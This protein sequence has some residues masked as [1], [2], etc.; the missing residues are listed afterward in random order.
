MG[1]TRLREWIGMSSRIVFFGGAGTSTESGIP[2]F[3]SEAGLFTTKQ[4]S[5]HSPEEMLSRSFFEQ[6][7]KEFYRFYYRKMIHADAE[8]NSGHQALAELEHRGKLR[9]IITQ[10]IDGLHQKAGSKS[11][12]ELHGSVHRNFCVQCAAFYTLEELMSLAG[13]VPLCVKCGSIVKP[14]VILYEEPLDMQLFAEAEAAIREA[15]LMIVAGTSLSVYPAAN[16]VPYFQGDRLAVI[17]KSETAY[18]RYAGCVVR[19]P[20]A[21]VMKEVVYD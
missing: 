5:S 12:L 21:Q 11:V 6:H 7:P 3:R 14:G 13:E 1:I 20:F 16:L 18:D 2:D 17:N 15:D 10:N 19:E 4:G 8:P 9:T